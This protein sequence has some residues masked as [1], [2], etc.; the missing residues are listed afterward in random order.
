MEQFGELLIFLKTENYINAYISHMITYFSGLGL[1]SNILAC[2]M[3]D[4]LRKVK[5]IHVPSVLGSLVFEILYN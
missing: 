2:N 4:T 1:L 3:D 5:S